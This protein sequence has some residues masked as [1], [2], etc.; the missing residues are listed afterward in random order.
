MT[1][2]LL[3]HA[4]STMEFLF[5]AGGLRRVGRTGWGYAG[6]QDAETVAEHS[7]RAAVIGAVLAMMEGADPARTAL[8]CVLHDTQE[9]RVGDITP[10]GR[11]YVKAAD[12]REVTA[13]QISAAHRP[14]G[15]ES[16][17]PSTSMK[18]ASPSR[19]P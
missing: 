9:T 4:A 1:D 19:P 16:R 8:L 7:H 6:I 15:Q 5:K 3:G 13:D 18:P 11:R 17:K 14:S 2:E 10:I 12:N